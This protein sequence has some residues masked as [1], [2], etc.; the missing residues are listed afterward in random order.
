MAIKRIVMRKDYQE[1]QTSYTYLVTG[2]AGFIGFHLA[3]Q[4]LDHGCRV[5]GY[6]NMNDYYD[7]TLKAER[8]EILSQHSSLFTFVEGDLADKGKLDKTFA[9]FSPHIVV[10]LAAQAGV[11]YSIDNPQAY[12]Q[13]N[14]V[15]F[16][17][18]LEAC[19]HSLSSIWYMPHQARSMG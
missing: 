9:D 16:L 7:T 3:K 18:V 8:L 12:M 1:L 14:L 2:S 15:G 4:L 19:R 17:N 11:R 13:S 5:I 10:N 6:D